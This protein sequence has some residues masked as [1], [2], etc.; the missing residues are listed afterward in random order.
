S[1]CYYA[2]LRDTDGGIDSIVDN[3][4]ISGP[5]ILTVADGQ[6]LELAGCSDWVK[7]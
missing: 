6:F 2:V 3:N 4:N 1:Q 5:G 7:Q